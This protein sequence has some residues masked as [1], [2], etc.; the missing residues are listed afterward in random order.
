[1]K[2]DDKLLGIEKVPSFAREE[3]AEEE[4]SECLEAGW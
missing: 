2:S 4:I 3:L 1:M